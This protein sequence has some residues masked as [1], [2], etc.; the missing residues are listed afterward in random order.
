M[1]PFCGII[2]CRIGLHRRFEERY[3]K[4]VTRHA[5][6]PAIWVLSILSQVMVKGNRGG[7]VEMEGTI[8][9]RFGGWIGEGWKMFAEQWKAWVVNGL[10]AG[11]I[12]ALP[13]AP[14]VILAFLV[15]SQMNGSQAEVP[16]AFGG[17]FALEILA[18]LF[19]TVIAA[20]FSAG[21]HRS[22]L[23]Q[24]RGEQ[25]QVSDLFSGGDCFFRVLGASILGGHP[26]RHRGYVLH[27]PG[28]YGRWRVVLHSIP[29]R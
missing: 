7:A 29:D 5:A 1:R 4:G 8:G 17:L 15:M 3:P 16:I 23:K 9:D 27:T 26:R 12:L 24:L 2:R 22:V 6:R 21:M 19:V 10:V 25:V 18:G 13:I 28:P 20:Y 14:I 11:A